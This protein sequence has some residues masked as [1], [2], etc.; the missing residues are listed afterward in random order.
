VSKVLKRHELA[1]LFGMRS[2]TVRNFPALVCS[3]CKAVFPVG[4]V[5]E[6]VATVLMFEV[7]RYGALGPYEARFLRKQIGVTQAELAHKLGRSRPTVARWEDEDGG[8]VSGTD[9]FA[10]R[11]L[12]AATVF[13]DDKKRLA[14]AMS[15][16][17]AASADAHA[18]A[19]YSAELAA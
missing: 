13:A 15:V 6:H 3:H 19:A 1:P 17:A 9:S 12:A 14:D 5:L 7:L 2:V 11:S 10:L 18:P 4:E 16:I 8:G